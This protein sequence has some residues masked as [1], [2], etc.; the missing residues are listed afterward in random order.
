MIEDQQQ[1]TE[2]RAYFERNDL[3]C[4]NCGVELPAE[5]EQ[6]AA[7]AVEAA[8]VKHSFG[9]TGCGAS[10][11]YDAH[12]QALRCPFCGRAALRPQP[13]RRVLRAEGGIP[14]RIDRQAAE[15]QLRQFLGS[16]FWH[17]GDLASAAK[18][19]Q[20]SPVYVPYWVFSATADVFYCG[21]SSA[22]P[23]GA[24]GDWVPVTGKRRQRYS[25]VLIGGSSVLTP[26]ETQ[27]LSPFSLAEQQSIDALA[28]GDA[29]VE[30]FRVSRKFAR[31][32]ARAA[33]EQL[34]RHAAAAEIP[35]RSRNV[36]V[37][38]LLSNMV[39][40][41]LLL[42][43]WIM[44][45]HYRDETYRVLINGQSGKLTGRAPW[46]YWKLIGIIAGALVTLLIVMAILAASA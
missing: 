11:A 2:C 10:M 12:H 27:E 39:G 19:H 4:H 28:P 23:P 31:P 15:D 9:C 45:Y 17:P 26:V 14:F 32:L 24:R 38:V 1:C 37:N 44:A 42:P 21:D 25:G 20:V 33:I 3:F 36:K 41:P 6:A 18:I 30:D 8:P 43:V 7:V 13:E 22:T 29:A 40:R 34:E 35:G 16:S 5:P 46:S